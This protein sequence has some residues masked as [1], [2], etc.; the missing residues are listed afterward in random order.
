MTDC[1][2]CDFGVKAPPCGLLA[3]DEPA[4]EGL[5]AR[6]GSEVFRSA[7]AMAEVWGGREYEL[8]IE[9]GSDWNTDGES[10]P[11]AGAA[12]GWSNSNGP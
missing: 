12:R 3:R 1:V 7:I 9:E 4:D 2:P 11:C 6:L 10:C 5:R 8:V